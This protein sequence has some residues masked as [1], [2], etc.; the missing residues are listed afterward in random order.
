MISKLSPN[1]GVAGFVLANG[2]LSTSQ[3]E[4][5]EIRKNI[6]E[7]GL[8]DCIVAMPS[9]LFYDVSIPVSLWFVSKNKNGR[10]DKVL[11]ID[12]RKMG[13]M[14]TRKHREFTD[15]ESE[16]IYSTYHAWRDDK[17][18]QDIDGF[19]KSTTLEEIRTHDYVLTP[20]RYVGIEEVEDDGI[21]FEEKM[22]KLT[23]ELSELF[24]ESKSLEKKIKEN[25]RGIGNEI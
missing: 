2:S 1:R 4:E 24:E 10:K 23:S 14:E 8:V 16:K 20:G 9:Q 15:E 7:E 25:L 18:F 6:L 21:P 13:Y 22:E 3:K 5:Y 12:A 17:D 19:C 11:F